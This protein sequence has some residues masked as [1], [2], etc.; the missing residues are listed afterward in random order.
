MNPLRLSPLPSLRSDDLS[1][2][3]WIEQEGFVDE[4]VVFALTLPDHSRS[5]AYREDLVLSA[6]DSDFAGWQLS[7]AP[8]VSAN[9][10]EVISRRPTPPYIEEPG[11][12]TPHVG[13]HRWWLAGLTGVLSTVLFSGLLLHLASRPSDQFEVISPNG[14]M[15]SLKQEPVLKV[16]SPKVAPELTEVSA[17]NP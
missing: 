10:A 14:A 13:A 17:Q 8:Q 3:L 12:G 15:A 6:D 7:P 2:S 1:R 5:V 16:N 9:R 4:E 11:L